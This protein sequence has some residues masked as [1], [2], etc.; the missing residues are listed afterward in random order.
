MSACTEVAQASCGRRLRRCLN[1]HR[2]TS[3][4]VLAGATWNTSGRALPELD[5]ALGDAAARP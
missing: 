2:A 3:G 1:A 5:A 4:R